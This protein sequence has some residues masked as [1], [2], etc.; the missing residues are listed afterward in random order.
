[1]NTI[2]GSSAFDFPSGSPRRSCFW[3]GVR[4]TLLATC[5]VAVLSALPVLAASSGNDDGA[6]PA[7]GGANA[8]ALRLSSVEGQVRVVQDGQIVADPALANMPLFA[9]SEIT[10][11]NDGRVE[12]QLED[13]SVV[14]LSPNSTL[15]FPAL[16]KQGTGNHTEVALT[17]G[18]AYFELQPSTSENSIRVSYGGATFAATSFSVVRITLDAPPGELAVFS[19]NVHLDRGDALQLDIHGGE[20]LSLDNGDATRYNLTETIRPDSWD[21][22]N[23]DRDQALNAQSSEQTAATS[24][25]GTSNV[26]IADLDA[27]G[28][29][30]N[31]PGQ[32]YLWSPYDAQAQGASWDPYGY[33]HWV[34]YP[35]RGWV[36]VSGYSW[37]YAAFDC[38]SWNYFDSFGWG[39]APGGGCNP[40]WS[41]GGGWGYNIGNYPRG[42]KPPRRPILPPRQPRTVGGR[43]V[44][45][46][47]VVPIDK[48]VAGGNLG[49]YSNLKQPVT[50]AGH[51]VEPLKPVA[52]RESYGHTVGTVAATHPANGYFPAPSHP[53]S[54]GVASGSRPVSGGSYH[55]TTSAGGS[56]S[57]ASSSS[58]GSS[59]VSSAG[60]ASS[61]G[62][63][64]HASGGGGGGGGGSH[65]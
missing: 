2:A 15:S 39:W 51:T 31:V 61:G 4:T 27:N 19:G 36:W 53:V 60:G 44:L 28:N 1:M 9:G 32:G 12:V 26:G 8:R 45:A 10:T 63:G 56:H 57:Y 30:Y 41:G 52:P 16:E 22:W 50:I 18:L 54:P 58:G 23:A 29:W 48:R 49:I 14:R 3:R 20:S 42:Y 11:G 38:G 47:N 65:H 64:G 21:T 46:S 6:D 35:G 43:T 24:A 17:N 13:G 55:G 5:L 59:H 33:G 25:Y 62:G 34:F 37:G 40:W 7:A